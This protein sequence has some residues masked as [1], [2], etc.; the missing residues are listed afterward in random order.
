MSRPIEGKR[1]D[2]LTRS[3]AT[4]ISRRRVMRA[5]I[6]RV[7]PLAAMTLGTSRAE[8]AQ[9]LTVA[10]GVRSEAS[11]GKCRGKVA[12][13]N[14]RCSADTCSGNGFCLCFETTEGDKRCVNRIGIPCPTANE[15]HKSKQ[16]RRGEVCVKRGGC[17]GHPKRHSCMP[18]CGR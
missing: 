11:D 9:D 5:L 13:N 12:A 8:A 18:L 10:D 16:C 17:C 1:F 3:L 6:A 7:G 14:Q 4:T 15:C 2:Q